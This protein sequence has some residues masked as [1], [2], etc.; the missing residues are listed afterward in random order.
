[1]KK[2]RKKKRRLCPSPSCCYLLGGSQRSTFLLRLPDLPPDLPPDPDAAK[3]LLR[4]S[5]YIALIG[6][7]QLTVAY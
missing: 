4:R 6:Y 5:S 1:M 2:E 7:R 3:G